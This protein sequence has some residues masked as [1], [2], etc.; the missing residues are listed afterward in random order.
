MS[1]PAARGLLAGIRLY[2]RTISPGLGAVCRFEPTCSRYTSEA[3]EEHGALRG[4][5][6]G[7][8]RLARCHP[9]TEGGY[10]PVPPSKHVS[11]HRAG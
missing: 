11:G 8:R 4:A 2:Q 3:I 7:L 9:G 1:S 10:D 5:W 6:L